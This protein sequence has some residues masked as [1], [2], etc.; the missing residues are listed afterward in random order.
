MSSTRKYTYDSPNSETEV[1]CGGGESDQK[2]RL[3]GVKEEGAEQDGGGEEDQA[4]ARLTLTPAPWRH[5]QQQQQEEQQEEQ[6]E[7]QQ[8]QQEQLQQP[9][10][11]EKQAQCWE[12]QLQQPQQKEAKAAA[13]AQKQRKGHARAWSREGRPQPWWDD[14]NHTGAVPQAPQ[15]YW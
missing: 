12:E 11:E 8:Q 9:Q 1:D 2:E 14:F 13:A 15:R 5:Q 6:E 3:E 7:P 10:Q 4:R